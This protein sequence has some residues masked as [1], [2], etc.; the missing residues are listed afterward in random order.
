[1]ASLAL[2]FYQIQSPLGEL[3]TPP[4]HSSRRPCRLAVMSTIKTG[5]YPWANLVGISA[6]TL[7]MLLRNTRNAP[8]NRYMKTWRHPQNRKYIAYC[9]AS[10]GEPSSQGH[11]QHAQ[12]IRK[13]RPCGFR[14]MQADRQTNGQLNRHTHHNTSH[15]CGSMAHLVYS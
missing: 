2:R 4:P 10:R 13:V 9:N 15:P 12:K 1:M 6:V 5:V 7:D 14:V 11:M 3:T 8:Q